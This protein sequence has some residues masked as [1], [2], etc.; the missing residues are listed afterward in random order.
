MGHLNHQQSLPC[1]TDRA[2][3]DVVEHSI[4]SLSPAQAVMIST[5]R[6]RYRPSSLSSGPRFSNEI[7]TSFGKS[8]GH[9]VTGQRDM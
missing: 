2:F 8:K 1:R 7:A 3:F 6:R 5:R 9:A 4:G